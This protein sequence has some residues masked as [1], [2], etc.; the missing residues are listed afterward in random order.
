MRLN[1]VGWLLFRPKNAYSV[2]AEAY[3]QIHI[4]IIHN[5]TASKTV[6]EYPLYQNHLNNNDTEYANNVFPFI[7]HWHFA[8]AHINS[9]WKYCMD[10]KIISVKWRPSAWHINTNGLPFV[11]VTC[12]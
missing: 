9:C 3:G 4:I 7:F 8:R 2:T 5:K 10:N 1:D 6:F 11:N 12:M